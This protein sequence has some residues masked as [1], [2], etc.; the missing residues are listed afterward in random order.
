MGGLLH[1]VQRKGAWA[2]CGPAQAPPR[3]TE[4][5]SLPINGQCTN[6]CIA[7]GWPLLCRFSVAIKGL[8]PRDGWLAVWLSS[9]AL[10]S[11]NVVTLRRARLIP[12]WV[13]VFGRVNYLC[14]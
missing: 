10:V 8:N 13:T 1:S 14:M 2:G 3:C 9:N 4:C 5:N 12:G 11:I 6:H 7:I